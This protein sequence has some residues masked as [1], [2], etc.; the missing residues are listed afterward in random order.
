MANQ[1]ALSVIFSSRAQKEINE[2]WNWYEE[3]QPG[4]GDRFLKELRNRIYIIERTPGKFPAR[5][6]TYK[7]AQVPVFPFCVIYRINNKKK[8]IRIVSIF[9]TS[10]NPKKKY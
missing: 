2:S 1:S 7:E 6:K 3:R 5:F 9:H 8:L 10:R 4:L